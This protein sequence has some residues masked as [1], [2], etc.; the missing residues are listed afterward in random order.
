MLD[1]FKAELL[2]LRVRRAV[3]LMLIALAAISAAVPVLQSLFGG[4]EGFR[5]PPDLLGA[6]EMQNFG[7]FLFAGLG[8]VLVG[9]EFGSRVMTT[10]LVR[11]Q[12]RLQLIGAKLV[13]F[14]VLGAAGAIVIGL[15]IIVGALIATLVGDVTYA[16]PWFSQASGDWALGLVRAALA[17]AAGAIFGGACGMIARSTGAAVGIAFAFF[18]FIEPAAI[19]LIDLVWHVQEQPGLFVAIDALRGEAHQPNGEMAMSAP[20]AGLALAV[21]L[22]ALSALQAGLFV[23]RD[24]T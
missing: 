1:A 14:C 4:G 2:K 3:H 22:A 18:V 15:S 11:G 9:G 10:E 6:W 5:V 23:R 7:A 20:E 21:W 17:L 13:A 19:A 12:T 16:E 8:A 24:I